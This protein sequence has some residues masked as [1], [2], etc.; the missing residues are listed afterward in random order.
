[1]PVITA[2]DQWR[3]DRTPPVHRI[4][5]IQWPDNDGWK[6]QPLSKVYVL[7]RADAD[8]PAPDWNELGRYS[9]KSDAQKA[10]DSDVGHGIPESS[11]QT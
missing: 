5:R 1:M 4:Y 8:T 2:P 6:A 3:K 10:A 9:S 7:S 11:W